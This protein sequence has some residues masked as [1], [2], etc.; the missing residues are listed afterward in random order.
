MLKYDI[1][2]YFDYFEI[3]NSVW[4]EQLKVCTSDMELFHL[5]TFVLLGTICK[6][7]NCF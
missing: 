3:L 7:N 6:L 1:K 5:K 4:L 2:N